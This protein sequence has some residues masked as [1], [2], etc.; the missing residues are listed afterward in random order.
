MS[1]PDTSS[2]STPVRADVA[3][4]MS[5]SIPPFLKNEIQ[6]GVNEHNIFLLPYTPATILC[7]FCGV[8]T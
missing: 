2:S 5:L 3:R 7:F 1:G 8:D 6:L 4:D